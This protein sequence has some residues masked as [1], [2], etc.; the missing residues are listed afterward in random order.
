LNCTK[1]KNKKIKIKKIQKK[2]KWNEAESIDVNSIFIPID[3]V[4]FTAI[5]AHCTPVQVVDLLN[6]LYT[7]FDA[8]IISYPNVYKV[9]TIGEF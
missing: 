3:I 4:G 8:T 1:R 2:N 5:A 7:C 9:E 6:D